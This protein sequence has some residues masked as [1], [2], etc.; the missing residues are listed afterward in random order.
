M[1]QRASGSQP[2][3]LRLRIFLAFVAVAV[4]SAVALFAGLYFGYARNADTDTLNGVITGGTIAGFLILSLLIGVWRW[5]DEHIAKPIEQLA[6]ELRARSHA[7]VGKDLTDMS[8]RYLGDLAPAA[9]ALIRHL[10]AARNELAEAVARETTR[11]VI[12][13]ERLLTLVADLPVGIVLCTADH[14]L[15]LYNGLAQKLLG[16]GE[17]GDAPGLD[18]LLF[19]YVEDTPIREAYH[20]LLR[21][22]DPDAQLEITCQS[23]NGYPLIARMRLLVADLLATPEDSDAGYA[24]TLEMGGAFPHAMATTTRTVAYDFDLLMKYRNDEFAE[25]LLDNLTYV[26]FDTET[27]GLLPGSGDEIV[28]LA[29]VRIVNGKRVETEVLDTLVN[30]GRPIPAYSTRIHGI[31][32]AMVA[33]C[34]GIEVAARRLH[35]FA[36][37]AVLVA[38]NADFDMAFLHR[39]EAHI[40]LRFDHPVLDTVMLSAI[41]FGDSANHSLDALTTRLGIDLSEEAR[42]TAIGDA[43][44][45]AEVLLKLIPALQARGLNTLGDV[46]EEVHRHGRLRTQSR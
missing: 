22:D 42:H 27:T 12:E 9:T 38:H 16:E 30:P 23:Y 13:K 2:I 17:S 26:V 29:A 39:D 43:S 10:N 24:L 45:T 4:G 34:P 1:P 40:G 7:H 11:Q 33:H 31:T 44:A 8:A 41:L 19:D 14:R 15:V 20:R 32:D 46:L 18:R 35:R 3:S 6:G 37:G 25:A 36:Q 28:Q 21:S 5:L